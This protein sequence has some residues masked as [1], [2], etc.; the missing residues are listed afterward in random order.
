M[1]DVTLTRTTPGPV[2]PGDRIFYELKTSGDFPT[3]NNLLGL[4]AFD[5]EELELV[6]VG[7]DPFFDLTNVVDYAEASGVPEAK[8]ITATNGTIASTPEISGAQTVMTFTFDVKAAGDASVS[9]NS[10]PF[11]PLVRFDS[12]PV[13]DGDVTANFTVVPLATPLAAQGDSATVLEDG[14]VEI[15]VLANDGDRAD[16]MIVGT[17]NGTNGEVT[18]TA[19]GLTYKPRD[20]FNGDDSFTYDVTDGTETQ[21]VTV[22]V[23]VTPVN[24]APVAADDGATVVA[25]GSVAVDVLDNDDD[26]DGDDL[27]VTAAGGASNGRVDFTPQGVTYTPD[28]GHTGTDS[29][30][31][32]VSDGRATP[33]PRRWT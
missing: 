1:V 32:E 26:A 17:T 30:T 4:L 11:G 3:F 6:G 8:L 24:D 14:T 2:K 25:G 7:F 31:Y 33:T 15:E 16:L 21:T 12:T 18:Q 5:V 13:F 23:A 27:T 22:D 9:F 28:A 10:A 19:D 29:F 20:N